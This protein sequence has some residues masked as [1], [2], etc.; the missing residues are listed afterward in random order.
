MGSHTPQNLTLQ[1]NID[2]QSTADGWPETGV[3][4]RVERPSLPWG[5]GKSLLLEDKFLEG[6]FLKCGGF[7]LVAEAFHDRAAGKL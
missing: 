7:P 4:C 1:W 6:F 5:H 2:E 3:S